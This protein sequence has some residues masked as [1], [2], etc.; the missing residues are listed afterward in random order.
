MDGLDLLGAADALSDQY[1]TFRV[2]S[3][4]RDKLK[5]KL[6][7]RTGKLAKAGLT[8]VDIAPK[9]ALDL[10]VPIVKNEAKS[11]GVDTEIVVSNV[12]PSK[13]GRAISEFFPGVVVGIGVGASGLLIIKALAGLIHK[14]L[15]AR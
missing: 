14:A 12:P 11:Y 8:F 3:V 15:P 1:I 4:D 10:V 5:E 2:K 13:G 7:G 9:A 6:G